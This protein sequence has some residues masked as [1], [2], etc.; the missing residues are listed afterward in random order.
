LT[1]DLGGQHLVGLLEH[2][3]ERHR[4][5]LERRAPEIVVEPDRL[6]DRPEAGEQA[7]GA[8]EDERHGAGPG[9]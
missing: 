1:S 3:V 7:L 6:D 4:P 5:G 8:D 2:G 9:R